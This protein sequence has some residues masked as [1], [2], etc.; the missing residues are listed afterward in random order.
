MAPLPQ[1]AP[2]GVQAA[3]AWH[4]LA[5]TAIVALSAFLNLF[6]L[7]SEGYG[8]TY[9]AATV[10]NMLTSGRNFFFASFD[11]GFVTVDKPPLGFWIQAASANVFGFS[12]WSIVLPQAI[13]GVLSVGLVYHLVRRAMGAVAGLLA[14]LTLALTPISVAINR[15]NNVEGVLVLVI[16]LAAWAFV[17]AT[18]TGRLPWLLLGAVLVGLGFNIKMLEAFLV[19][20]AFY[21]LYLTG[22][23]GCWPR[24]IIHLG[25]ATAVLLAVS[26]SWA[27]AVDLTPPD[28]RPYVGTSSNNTVMDLIVGFNGAN[29]LTG[30][31]T[32]VG[33]RGP[34][35]LLMEPLVGQIGWLLPLAAVGLA[36]AVWHVRPL[37]PFGR[38]QQALVLW[39]TWFLTQWVFFNIAGDWDPHYLAV[40]APAVAALV[41]IGVVALRTA[42]RSPARLGWILPVMLAV[43]AGLHIQVLTSYP[44]WN[45][46]LRL[47]IVMLCLGAVAGLVVVRVAP[48]LRRT[49]YEQAAVSIGIV[50]LL[51]AP[52]LWAGSTIWYGS[53]TRTPMAGPREKRERSTTSH[54][55]RDAA[56]LLGYLQSHQ[57]TATYLVATADQDFARYAILQT[58]D[59]VIATGGFKGNDRVL[60][61][62]RLAGLV[63][64]GAV[65][66][67]LLETS[68]RKRNTTATWITQHCMPIPT[69]AWQSKS[70]SPHKAGRGIA[71]ALYDCD[72]AREASGGAPALTTSHPAPK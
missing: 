2:I 51:I 70:T 67:F 58:N 45:S 36:V 40:L 28:Q 55:V 50:S 61:T 22:A 3:V 49:G 30:Q 41:G 64:D 47:P 38:R 6:H 23:P 46:W 63:T 53:E 31:D 43:T 27:M 14:A 33:D 52:S 21:L 34:L 10:K 68:I 54:F 39:G 18:E 66:F 17:L 37:R 9:Y 60:S 65:R 62:E 69:E 26:L 44:N 13:A 42:Y 59:L 15:H 29:R 71:S 20:P 1:S 57:G 56:P 7:T 11:A 16:L 35:R 24:R 48:H 32:D 8:N 25:L 5:L 12:G 19:L 4:R 72:R